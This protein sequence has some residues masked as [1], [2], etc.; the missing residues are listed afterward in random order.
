MKEPARKVHRAS[1]K[2]QTV[3]DAGQLAMQVV[4]QGT[5]VFEYISM[6]LLRQVQTDCPYNQPTPSQQSM[7]A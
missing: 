5:L 2:G 1:S 7:R 3:A 6:L 4:A